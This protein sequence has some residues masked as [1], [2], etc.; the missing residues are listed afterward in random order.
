MS[1]VICSRDRAALLDGAL[2]AIDGARREDD[3]TVLVDSASIDGSVR[4]TAAGHPAVMVVRCDRPGLARARNT[5]V[6]ASSKPLIA[7]TDDDCRPQRG[8]AES[9]AAVFASEERLGFV[10]GSVMPDRTDGPM[11]SI[12]AESEP[13]TFE[14]GVDPA[15]FGHGANFA[16]RLLG[17]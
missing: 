3:E 17:L 13:R 14:Y 1:I 10:T 15:E 5:G 8:W 11:L 6:R 7:F 2:E 9:I 16:V 12:L 4:E